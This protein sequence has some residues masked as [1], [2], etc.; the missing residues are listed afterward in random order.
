MG[1]LTG[2]PLNTLTY[3]SRTHEGLDFAAGVGMLFACGD[4]SVEKCID[5]ASAL[6]SEIVKTSAGA[7]KTCKVSLDNARVLLLRLVRC[8]SEPHALVEAKPRI[9]KE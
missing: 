2:I 1:N 9:L 7:T 8:S 6:F 5:A 3:R 4:A